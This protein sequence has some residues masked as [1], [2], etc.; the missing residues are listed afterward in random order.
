[1]NFTPDYVIGDLHLG[2]DCR[3]FDKQYSKDFE[4]VEDYHKAI[5]KNANEKITN[6]NAIVLFT[7]DIGK[8]E[9]FEEVLGQIKGRKFLILGNH[10]NYSKEVYKEYFEEVWN[11]PIFINRRVVASHIPI[12]TEPGVLNI[13]SHTHYIDLDS[14]RH[15]N[16]CPEKWGYKPILF[17]KLLGYLN[18]IEKPNHKFLNEWYA[19]IQR[20][21][22]ILDRDDI[23]LT[24]DG[25]IDIEKTKPL[26]FKIKY[27]RKMEK[28]YVDAL[29][30]EEILELYK[31]L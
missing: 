23:I 18:K 15:I 8:K 28:G 31:K 11:H 20:P 25:L 3:V 16:V 13:H 24:E 17:K 10:D 26:I 22:S 6:P 14:E 19:D 1:M 5:V 7:G 27:K 2:N 29:T 30:D 12:P 4:T 21:D 9:Y